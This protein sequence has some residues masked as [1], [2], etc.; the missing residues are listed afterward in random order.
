[1]QVDY[2]DISYNFVHIDP[3]NSDLLDYTTGLVKQSEAL[4]FNVAEIQNMRNN[5]QM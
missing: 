2:G 3:T 4:Y 1:M 5:Q